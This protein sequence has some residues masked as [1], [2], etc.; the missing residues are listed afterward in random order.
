MTPQRDQVLVEPQDQQLIAA[1]RQFI[2][3]AS[4]LSPDGEYMRYED[5]P[6][7]A[8]YVVLAKEALRRLECPQGMPDDA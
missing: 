4:I 2:D 7:I 5:G 6:P 3:Q 1:L 8:L